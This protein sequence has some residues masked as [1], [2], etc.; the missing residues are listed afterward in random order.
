MTET[1]HFK[2]QR[3][4]VYPKSDDGRMQASRSTITRC[5]RQKKKPPHTPLKRK[6]IYFS[7]G[8]GGI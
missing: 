7:Y 5:T 6:Y 8:G 4:R 2:Q 3:C 1:F